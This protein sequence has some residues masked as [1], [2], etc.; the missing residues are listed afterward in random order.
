[1]VRARISDARAAA[2]EAD[3]DAGILTIDMPESPW[4]GGLGEDYW[5]TDLHPGYLLK[6]DVLDP[7]DMYDTVM[8]IGEQNPRLAAV[9]TRVEELQRIY[10]GIVT[11]RQNYKPGDHYQAVADLGELAAALDNELAEVKA[12]ISQRVGEIRAAREAVGPAA[13]RMTGQGDMAMMIGGRKYTVPAAFSDR[14]GAMGTGYKAEASALTTQ[15]RTLDPSSGTPSRQ[16]YEKDRAARTNGPVEVAP[17]SPVYYDE[18]AYVGNR[19]FRNDRLI[20]MFLEG[21]S[22]ETI[23]AWLETPAGKA[24]QKKMGADYLA[25]LDNYDPIARKGPEIDPST[26][27]GASD[28]AGKPRGGRAEPTG[29][30]NRTLG[31]EGDDGAV[32]VKPTS[33]LTSTTTRLDEVLRVVEQYFPDEAVRR[34]LYEGEVTPGELQAALGGRTDLSPIMGEDLVYMPKPKWYRMGVFG[35]TMDAV[36][37]WLAANPEDRLARWP[38]YQVEF[39]ARLKQRAEILDQQGVRLDAEQWEALRQDSL[40]EALTELEKTFYNIRR[41]GTPV[42]QS[43]FLMSFPGAFFNSIYRYGRFAVKEP[44]R[45]IQTANLAHDILALGMVGE[46]GE[47]VDSLMDAEYVMFPTPWDANSEGVKIPISSLATLSVSYPGLSVGVSS[48]LSMVQR[49]NLKTEETIKA[50][51]GDAVFEQLFP[52]GI[53]D[54]PLAVGVAAY[55]KDLWRAVRGVED[56]DV[57]NAAIDIYGYKMYTW[58][59]AGGEGPAPTMDEAVDAAAAYYAQ[60]GLKKWLSPFGFIDTREGEFMRQAWSDIQAEYGGD[61]RG[62]REAYITKYGDAATHFTY[63]SNMRTAYI[64]PTME[65]YDRIWVNNPEIAKKLVGLDVKDPEFVS[66]LA[67]GT[68]GEYSAS[69]N[70]AMQRIPLPGD[71]EPVLA[72]MDPVEYAASVH[73]SEGWDLYSAG[74]AKYDADMVR[75]KTLRDSASN[76]FE[77][78]K[79]RD[80]IARKEASFDSWVEGIKAWNPT[81]AAAKTDKGAER[82]AKADLYLKTILGDSSFTEKNDPE[83]EKVG[84]FLQSRDN[85]KAQYAATTDDEEKKALIREYQ[86]FITV[87]YLTDDPTF[88]S[89]YD[90]YFAS[91]WE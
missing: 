24:Y 36:W 51:T 58:D 59:L 52:Y 16:N 21:K 9:R 60:R 40:R 62:A 29:P 80:E 18:L 88:S 81:W 78:S 46:D 3:P 66:L 67:Y 75:L 6:D 49:M 57:L 12:G 39:K 85:F 2:R 8:R 11:A 23:A 64:P 26:A 69:V 34:R 61:T 22:R 4:K 5:P 14:A 74:K 86:D 70:D 68:D 43:R 44:E 72:T 79:Y 35:R 13:H 83:W 90:R 19:Y 1:M 73:V 45:L 89:M 30:N 84:S 20:G 56:V 55:Q 15:E 48:I 28:V 54:N 41:Y 10:D 25:K 65:A 63:S 50:T 71:S 42:Y 17:D 32:G 37:S 7:P 31:F 33:V 77:R 82:A 38:M 87:E 27:T 76:E 53:G 47:R 91:E